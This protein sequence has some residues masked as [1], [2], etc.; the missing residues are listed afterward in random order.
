MEFPICENIEFKDLFIVENYNTI[1]LYSTFE[2]FGYRYDINFNYIPSGKEWRLTNLLH[3][4]FT[5][6]PKCKKYLD[7]T[8]KDRHCRYLLQYSDT[9][10]NE[11]LAD[12]I[13]AEK[14]RNFR[15][16]AIT[17]GFDY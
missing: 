5:A 15:L 9:I 14:M 3:P 17:A 1:K 16:E 7:H 8:W 10:K 4:D 6:C 13:I 2:H 11:I 12:S